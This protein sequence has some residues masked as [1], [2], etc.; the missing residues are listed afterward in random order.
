MVLLKFRA[1][2]NG[3]SS[4]EAK[5]NIPHADIS[6]NGCPVMPDAVMCN[7]HRLETPIYSLSFVE[8]DTSWDRNRSAGITADPVC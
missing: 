7:D 6:E 3:C 4:V 1:V 8:G 5:R 2:L